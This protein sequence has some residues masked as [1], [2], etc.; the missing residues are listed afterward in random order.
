MEIRDW[1]AKNPIATVALLSAAVAAFV[2]AP[3]IWFNNH[4][5]GEYFGA[6]VGFLAL[7]S[8]ALF[9]AQLERQRDDR[10]HLRSIQA[11]IA[12]TKSELLKNSTVIGQAIKRVREDKDTK[13]LGSSTFFVRRDYQ[14]LGDEVYHRNVENIFSGI[15][16][17]KV[18]PSE[19]AI[20]EMFYR[21]V[22]IAEQQIESIEELGIPAEVELSEVLLTTLEKLQKY[23][24]SSLLFLFR[25][26]TKLNPEGVAIQL[27]GLEKYATESGETDSHTE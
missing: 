18:D 2:V 16:L 5:G 24:N 21:L 1:A 9:N 20:L 11:S 19:A 17:A 13:K 6:L 8:G 26:E 15:L 25:V 4:G 7:L 22:P 12:A 27:A 14:L 3:L 23:A 10:L